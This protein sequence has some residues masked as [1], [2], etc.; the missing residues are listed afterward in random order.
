MGND[1]SRIPLL[2]GFVLAL[3]LCAVAGMIASSALGILQRSVPSVPTSSRGVM[4]Q[5]GLSPTRPFTWP[6]PTPAAQPPSPT[7]TSSP[8]APS[9]LVVVSPTPTP[10]SSTAIPTDTATP[11]STPT[12]T[13]TPT[14]VAV[15]SPTLTPTDTATPVPTPYAGPYREG[16]GVDLHA[17][18]LSTPLWLDGELGE[19]EGVAGQDL[20]YILSGAEAYEGM[21]DI[22]GT[23]YAQ[24]D[25]RYLYLAARVLDDV[26]VQ[27]QRGEHMGW[28]DS[29][30]V[31]LDA[32]LAEDFDSAVADEDD[33][34]IGLSPG[35]FAML[36]PEAVVWRPQ[37]RTDWDQ[38]IIVAARPRSDGYSLEAAIPWSILSRQP[39]VASAFGFSVQLLDNDQPRAAAQETMLT[40]SPSFRPGV[41][42]T[43]GNLILD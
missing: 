3:A 5:S 8:T 26:H 2:F 21:A 16:N 38:A 20:S 28:G 9:V 4:R 32:A 12:D 13:S 14:V 34:Q 35:D 29:L 15:P 10:E 7:P 42:T 23:V 43:F 17:R 25:E 39:T 19:W 37:R 40:G 18:H 11:T 36:P 22:A 27:T 6:T 1:G 41:P 33:F 30:I 31:W 24:W